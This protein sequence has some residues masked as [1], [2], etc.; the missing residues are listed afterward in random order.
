MK[1]KYFCTLPNRCY[2]SGLV[3]RRRFVLI[4]G[5]RGYGAR[6]I[7]RQLSHRNCRRCAQRH[8]L[9]FFPPRRWTAILARGKEKNE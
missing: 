8:R 3:R 5:H 2:F 9:S 6:L 7:R 1:T 4:E